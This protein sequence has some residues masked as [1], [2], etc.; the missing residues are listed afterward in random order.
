MLRF[1]AL[2]TFF[3]FF[4]FFDFLSFLSFLS[5]LLLLAL[6]LASRSRS[7]SSRCFRAASSLWHSIIEGSSVTK[8]TGTANWLN[9]L[10]FKSAGTSIW[11]ARTQRHRCP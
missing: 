7:S 1:F 3:D 11:G 5:F 6:S 8:R 4:D 9:D 2:L 10:R